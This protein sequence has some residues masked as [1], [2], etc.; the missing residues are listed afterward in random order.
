M[1]TQGRA[2]LTRPPAAWRKL[3]YM[4]ILFRT[5]TYGAGAVL[6]ASSVGLALLVKETI[7]NG[8][9]VD[10]ELG[11]LAEEAEAVGNTSTLTD[12]VA[13]RLVGDLVAAVN[14][15]AVGAGV[16][17]LLNSHG[18][19]RTTGNSGGGGGSGGQESDDGRGVHFESW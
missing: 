7:G 6:A 1:A 10:L 2:A 12:R 3:V 11:A 18:V 4:E 13:G 17:S 14:A 16:G 8:E 15:L 5:I 9:D 19:D